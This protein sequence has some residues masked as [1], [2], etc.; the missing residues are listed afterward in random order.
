MYLGNDQFSDPCHLLLY[1]TTAISQSGF[2]IL[3]RISFCYITNDVTALNTIVR[4][5]PV[6]KI[7]WYNVTQGDKTS[8]VGVDYVGCTLFADHVQ[9]HS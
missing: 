9:L 6:S 5:R 1:D 4:N 7:I 3:F 8:Q 2:V